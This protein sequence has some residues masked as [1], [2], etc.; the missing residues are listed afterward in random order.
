MAAEA[1]RLPWVTSGGSRTLLGDRVTSPGDDD[2]GFD[3]DDGALLG[4]LSQ[5]QHAYRRLLQS[6]SCFYTGH[7]TVKRMLATYTN[8]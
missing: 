5:V 3:V 1:V 7:G 4:V 2:E 6:N 8:F